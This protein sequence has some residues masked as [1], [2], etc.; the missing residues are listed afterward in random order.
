MKAQHQH[1][2][3]AQA[4]N[5]YEGEPR[6]GEPML[7]RVVLI[8]GSVSVGARRLERLAGLCLRYLQGSDSGHM[9]RRWT[10]AEPRLRFMVVL[11]AIIN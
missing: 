9:A 10:L 8:A 11:S 6:R 5:E 2:M 3:R 7:T 4:V 1:L